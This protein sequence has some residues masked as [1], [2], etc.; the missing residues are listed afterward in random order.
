MTPAFKFGDLVMTGELVI[1][2]EFQIKPY[3]IMTFIG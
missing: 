1:E 3:E 2:A